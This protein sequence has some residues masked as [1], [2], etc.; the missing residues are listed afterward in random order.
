MSAIFVTDQT[1]RPVRWHTLLTSAACTFGC[2]RVSG[3]KLTCLNQL[4]SS[5]TLQIEAVI[6]LL[7]HHHSRLVTA[8]IHLRMSASQSKA[9]TLQ[10]KLENNQYT[11]ASASLPTTCLPWQQIP[12]PKPY[13]QQPVDR[14]TS[15]IRKQQRIHLQ[16]DAKHQNSSPNRQPS[17]VNV[18]NTPWALFVF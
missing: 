8:G 1:G 2:L 15:A 12:R 13:S 7:H 16:N 5:C 18:N 14:S 17:G 11:P 9:G 4:H 3:C 6:S 10:Q